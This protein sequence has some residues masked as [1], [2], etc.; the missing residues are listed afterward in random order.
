LFGSQ[1]AETELALSAARRAHALAR[2]HDDGWSM[3]AIADAAGLTPTR[4]WRL[5]TRDR[6]G[7]V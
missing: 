4:V 2:L 7:R 1:L 5:I 3:A 6:R